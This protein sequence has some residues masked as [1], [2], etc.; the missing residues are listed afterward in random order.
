MIKAV[1]FDLDGTLANTFDDLRASIDDMRAAYGLGPISLEQMTSFINASLR[2]FAEGGLGGERTEEEIQKAM[3]IYCDA[4]SKHYIEKTCIYEGL[5]ELLASLK[6]KG[7]RL[8]VY[9]NK[10]A[11]YVVKIC[12]KLYGKETFEVLMGP[13]GITPKPNPM[14]ALIAAEK[15]GVSPADVAYVGDSVTD[16]KTGL[17]AGMHTIGVSWGFTAREDLVNAGAHKIAD[18]VDELGAVLASL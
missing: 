15:M 1:V 5:P 9:S 6:A 4:Y 13:D 8:A 2:G 18:T 10:M 14:G 11:E 3:E 12:E 7:V 16:M 17:A